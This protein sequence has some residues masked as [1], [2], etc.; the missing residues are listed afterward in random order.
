MAALRGAFDRLVG[1]PA[2]AYGSQDQGDRGGR[3]EQVFTLQERFSPRLA[4]HGAEAQARLPIGFRGDGF[5][6]RASLVHKL[7]Y[8]SGQGAPL[9]T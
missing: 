2:R 8:A 3:C 7:V 6:V 5:S 9:K 4:S 1:V